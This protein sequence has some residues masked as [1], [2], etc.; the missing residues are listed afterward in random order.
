MNQ[1]PQPQP[2]SSLLYTYQRDLYVEAQ[3]HLNRMRQ[4]SENEDLQVTAGARAP[5]KRSS[6]PALFLTLLVLALV[7]AFI[8]YRIL[9]P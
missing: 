2:D 3:S 4:A 8:I 5:R 7:A 1:D 6:L 9:V